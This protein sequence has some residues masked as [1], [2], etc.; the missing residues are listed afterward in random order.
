MGL[1]I[2]KEKDMTPFAMA[3][4]PSKQYPFLMPL[5]WGGSWLL[6]REFGLKIKKFNMDKIKPPFLVIG[7][8]Q[9]PVDYYVGP[10]AM[11]PHRAMYVSDMEGFAAFGKW[12]YRGLGCIGKRRYVSDISVVCNMKYALSIGQSVV[13]YPESRHSNVGTTAFVPS[14]M[15]KLAKAMGVPVVILAAK[16]NYLANP[17]WDE[18]H[19]RKVPVEVSMTCICG[20]D[21]LASIDEAKLQNMIED[22][23]A[24]DEYRY[25]QD[26]HIKIKDKNRAVG[27]H[28]ALYQCRQCETKYKMKSSGALLSC[29]NCGATYELSESGWLIK[30]DKK[31]EK[32]HIPDWYE[33]EREQAVSEFR[34]L[35]VVG[36]K[37]SSH[38]Y[39]LP[40]EKGF[41][42]LGTGELSVDQNEFTLRFDDENKRKLV[43][44]KNF[45]E[46][47]MHFPHK[48]RESVQTEYDYKGTGMCIVL[49]TTDCCYYIYSDDQD[50]NPTEL[51]FI[52][53]ALYKNE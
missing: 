19:T 35:G 16:G 18:E 45:V 24:Y 44:E 51:Q 20:K 50:F 15:G 5:V 46:Y 2:N 25:Q 1:V 47:T 33:W 21:E 36:R 9:G 11:F 28:K 30:S 49:S 14:N 13:V 31:D 3:E 48:I 39:A 43:R 10:L 26:N 40:N 4:K 38:I 27:L 29:E 34:E 52:G 6:T 7:T 8:H 37:F 22:G 12:L 41:V 23:L 17:F 42:D 53:E 32:M